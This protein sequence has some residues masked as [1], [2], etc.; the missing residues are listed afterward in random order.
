MLESLTSVNFSQR[1]TQ[2]ANNSVLNI[3]CVLSYNAVYETCLIAT[4]LILLSL[5]QVSMKSTLDR[6]DIFSLILT[7]VIEKHNLKMWNFIYFRKITPNTYSFAKTSILSLIKYSHYLHIS[8]KHGIT[9]NSTHIHWI[10]L[11]T[12]ITQQKTLLLSRA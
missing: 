5:W 2:F 1:S 9:T 4:N 8:F 7:T 11:K 3:T 12:K 10:A 6:S